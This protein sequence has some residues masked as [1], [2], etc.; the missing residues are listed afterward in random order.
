MA[1]VSLIVSLLGIVLSCILGFPLSFLIGPYVGIAIGIVGLALAIIAL[2]KKREN[3][4]FAALIISIIVI[5]ICIFRMIS[6]SSCVNGL[7]GLV[8]GA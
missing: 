3:V 8:S 2:K 5:L 4:S 6:M 1:V 7:I